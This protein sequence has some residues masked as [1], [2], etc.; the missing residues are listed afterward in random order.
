VALTGQAGFVVGEKM[1][2]REGKKLLQGEKDTQ[3]RGIHVK[4]FKEGG[5]FKVLNCVKRGIL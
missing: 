3:H 2:T 1:V 4:S 5:T